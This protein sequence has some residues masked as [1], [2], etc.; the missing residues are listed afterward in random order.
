M[1]ISGITV[2]FVFITTCWL[3]HV[4]YFMLVS[5]AVIIVVFVIVIVAE[6]GHE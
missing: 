4:G 2:N 6:A 3:F 1:D 5:F